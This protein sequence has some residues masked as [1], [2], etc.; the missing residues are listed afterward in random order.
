MQYFHHNFSIVSLELFISL[1]MAFLSDYGVKARCRTHRI[2]SLSSQSLWV[3]L[4]SIMPPRRPIHNGL[5]Y[6]ASLQ[7][8]FSIQIPVFLLKGIRLHT[9]SLHTYWGHFKRKN[10]KSL[11]S[12]GCRKNQLRALHRLMSIKYCVANDSG[13][14]MSGR[15][16]VIIL[17]S[18]LLY[19]LRLI[20]MM[21]SQPYLFPHK[22]HKSTK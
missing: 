11:I 18:K 12:F 17:S 1:I 2:T 10:A 14:Q 15:W 19:L 20:R 7:Q 21:G 5:R 8:S 6:I 16:L 9:C 4:S 13:E 3:T 22:L